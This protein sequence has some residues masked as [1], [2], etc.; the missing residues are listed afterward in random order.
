MF[1]GSPTAGTWSS[2][3]WRPDNEFETDRGARKDTGGD[4]WANVWKRHHFAWEYKGRRAD[5][6]AAFEQLRQ[7]SLAL[8]NPPLLIVSDMRRFRIRTN[9]TNSVSQTHDFRSTACSSRRR[10]SASSA[11][12]RKSARPTSRHRDQPLC[13]R[14]GPR[15]GLDRRNPVDAAQRLRGSARPDPEAARHHRVPRCDPDAGQYR[16]GLGRRS[17]S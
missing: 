17:M 6:D 3:Q 12:F 14:A 4:G 9:W 2:S 11:R 8:E 1:V 16:T 10:H 7:Y 13:R 5:L 15:R